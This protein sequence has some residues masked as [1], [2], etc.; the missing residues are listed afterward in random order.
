VNKEE[1]TFISD[2]LERHG[3]PTLLLLLGGWYISSS[4]LEPMTSTAKQFITDIRE[5]NVIIQDELMQIDR[6]NLSRWDKAFDLQQRNGDLAK[7]VLERMRA[8]E[9][10]TERVLSEFEK[11]RMLFTQPAIDD[12]GLTDGQSNYLSPTGPYEDAPQE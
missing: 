8:L 9:V 7:D 3:L 1:G 4:V 10:K 11:M 12:K 5:A 2:F 6:E